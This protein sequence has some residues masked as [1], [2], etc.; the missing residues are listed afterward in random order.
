M[1]SF[2]FACLMAVFFLLA[3]FSE[4]RAEAISQ[5]K[6]SDLACEMA[7]KIASGELAFRNLT[8][9]ERSAL[10]LFRQKDP[11]RYAACSKPVFHKSA[12]YPA[13]GRVIQIFDPITLFLS[14]GKKVRLIGVKVA[15]KDQDAA[16]KALE[17]FVLSHDVRLEYDVQMQDSAGR[18]LAYVFQ[19]DIF[20]NR[21]LVEKG[22]AEV[23]VSPPNQ[24]YERR[25]NGLKDSSEE[26]FQFDQSQGS[27]LTQQIYFL[28]AGIMISFVILFWLRNRYFKR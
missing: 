6:N 11:V 21:W 17:E 14:N 25:L 18:L 22:L 8:S 19:G 12:S 1:K 7:K 10:G 16:K 15:L 24:R 2:P 28:W 23:E 3:S 20:V 27:K 9:D 13:T 5:N 4:T 26:E